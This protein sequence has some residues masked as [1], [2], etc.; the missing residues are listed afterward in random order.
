M[1]C[2]RCGNSLN[3]EAIFC[4]ECG[5][6]TNTD[7]VFVKQQEK[8]EQFD[9]SI[10]FY[11]GE[12]KLQYKS[13]IKKMMD[14]FNEFEHFALTESENFFYWYKNNVQNV[15]DILKKAKL[16]VE[17][18]I[19]SSI[20]RAINILVSNNVLSV[21]VE[22]FKEMYMYP[23]FDYLSYFEDVE[24]QYLSIISTEEEMEAYR[25]E[26][27]ARRSRWQGGGFGIKGAIK[28]AVSAGAMNIAT[29][30][31][32]APFNI[33]SKLS[34][35]YKI[36][37]MKTELYNSITDNNEI[38]LLVKKC[39]MGVVCGLL[40]E[41]ERNGIEYWPDF[42]ISTA[43]KIYINCSRQKIKLEKINSLIKCIQ[44][45]PFIDSA[46][47]YNSL[48]QLAHEYENEIAII[49]KFFGYNNVVE[50]YIK[51][52]FASVDQILNLSEDN[53]GNIELK[54]KKLKQ[55]LQET[56]L[57]DNNQNFTTA[58]Y[59]EFSIDEYI[60]KYKRELESLKKRK[61]IED[62]ITFE[63]LK[64][65]SEYISQRNILKN[66]IFKHFKV[67]NL[68]DI[69][70]FF[71]TEEKSIELFLNDINS[72]Q[73]T[74]PNILESIKK[75]KEKIKIIKN[76]R[77]QFEGAFYYKFINLCIESKNIIDG[78]NFSIVL[79]EKFRNICEKNYQLITSL[80]INKE[81]II[82]IIESS[83]KNIC[84]F[85]DTY[86]Y[87]EQKKIKLSDITEVKSYS[88]EL[89]KKYLRILTKSKQ[90]YEIKIPSHCD[91]AYELNTALMF[92]KA[93]SLSEDK[94]LQLINKLAE[95]KEYKALYEHC[96]AFLNVTKNENV[97]LQLAICYYQGKGVERNYREAF[98]LFEI[99]SK[100]YDN[101]VA[102]YYLGKC[103]E[104]G[105]GTNKNLV[106]SLKYYKKAAQQKNPE[107]IMVLAEAYSN[108]NSELV[109]EDATLAFQ[110]YE[111]A[112]RLGIPKAQYYLGEAYENGI[113]TEKNDELSIKWYKLAGENG[114]TKAKIRL[115]KKSKE[116]SNENL[117]RQII[118]SLLL[119]CLGVI[120][121]FVTF[122]ISS[123]LYIACLT[124]TLII[125][126][127]INNFTKYKSIKLFNNIHLFSLFLES[128]I[129]IYCLFK[130][131]HQIKHPLILSLIVVVVTIIV[132]VLI[133][134]KKEKNN[135]DI[136]ITRLCLLLI[137]MSFALII[138]IV[139]HLWLR[140]NWTFTVVILELIFALFAYMGVYSYELDIIL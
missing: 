42:D 11:I 72:I 63:T 128:I 76:Y 83:S 120:G 10:A 73:I 134:D 66:I 16:R 7:N 101:V 90:R 39:V 84:V 12:N 48:F 4:P 3:K 50:E 61:Y 123:S 44:L 118:K 122:N 116:D 45:N 15:A 46:K 5:H 85:T 117:N 41:I 21:T 30:V 139:A 89:N 92:A 38:P 94:Q 43:E 138:F 114:E 58:N 17:S 99:L 100:E 130:F 47:Y 68:N 104:L 24:E 110:Y 96:K 131:I 53:I 113:G 20:D 119:V 9:N 54:I 91:I 62:G 71:V 36:D 19:D 67:N 115:N 106:S 112:A 80:N 93:N 103:Y 102:Q 95:S 57:L 77:T 75:C 74:H 88:D 108:A 2:T 127:H 132:L 79:G 65:K 29:D 105:N 86:I 140:I 40:S 34:D 126:I 14:I 78:E 136:F 87:I 37:N 22:Q 121:A 60:D 124:Y 98:C 70:K 55:K 109:K 1:F 133:M 52:K 35:S 27:W 51:T 125:L 82:L 111:M 26:K 69:N 56:C 59:P 64:D 18:C 135:L 49:A 137:V 28:G 31:I 81:D 23:Y 97:Y 25:K 6:K 8:D 129:G 33:I 32:R 13:N 107:A